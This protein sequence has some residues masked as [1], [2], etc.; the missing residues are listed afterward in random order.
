MADHSAQIVW[1]KQGLSFNATVDNRTDMPLKF[2]WSADGEW[3]GLSPMG[4][5][6]ASLAACTSM[7]VVSIL[8]KKRQNLTSFEVALEGVQIN[9]HPRVYDT[10]TLVYRVGGDVSPEAVERAIELS[11]TKYCPV[12]AMLREVVNIETRYELI[13]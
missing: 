2:G 11:V 8:Q 5:V 6:L 10:I 13:G 1:N 3:D 12:N 9:D 4:M 7:D